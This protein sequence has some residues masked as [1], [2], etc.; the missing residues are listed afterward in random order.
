MTRGIACAD[1]RV[2][3]ARMRSQLHAAL[4]RRLSV[5]QPTLHPLKSP[6]FS[7]S[8]SAPSSERRTGGALLRGLLAIVAFT[9]VSNA[10]A[11]ED[12]QLPPSV[13]RAMKEVGIPAD[14][15]SILVRDA[16]T[17]EPIVELNADRPRSPASTIKALTTFVAL[18]SLGP[19]YTWKTRVYRTGKLTNGV[20]N[21]DLILVGGGDPYMTSER[22]WSLVQN[23]REL[24]LAKINGDIVIDNTYF[25][26]ATA[27]RRDF[28]DRPWRSYNVLPDALMV[29]FQTSRFT[30]TVNPQRS[31]PQVAV[32]PLPANLTVTNLAQVGS[33]KCQ[34][35]NGGLNFHTPEDGDTSTIIISGVMAASCGTISSSRAIMT[36][37]EYAYGTFRTLWIQSGGAIDGGLRIA[38]LPKEAIQL[39]AFDSLPMAEIIRLVN[40]FSNNVMARTLMLTLG[41]EKFGPP[42]TPQS[43]RNAIQQWLNDHQ[44]AIPGLMLE[45]GSGLSRDERVT[46]KGMADVLD[47]AWHSPFMPEFAASL[48]LAAT[49]GT[50]RNRFRA[51][52]MHGRLRL[53]T[54]R[55][56]D[57]SGLAGFVNAAS[58]KTYILVI[59]VNHPGA[60]TG[61]GEAVQA[62]LVRWVFGR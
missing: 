8:K 32:N 34:G 48:P 38:P 30:L 19:S 3:P 59:L 18:D 56:D 62:E 28:D 44:I 9:L 2:S 6:S 10:H 39:Y 57:V 47:V 17:S 51:A 31:R 60:H 11:R 25:A 40:K 42:A 24:G 29:N 37:S 12:S 22:W 36:A 7:T 1:E 35:E 61:S 52:G 13:V 27:S 33:G 20:L 53:K 21:G 49:D 46:V 50:L 14:H 5:E 45:N 16:A 4:L 26:P 43:G 54:G 55:I 41:A 15:V 58:G 23:L